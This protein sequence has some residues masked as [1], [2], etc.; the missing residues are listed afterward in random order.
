M[1]AEP[2]FA[3]GPRHAS[4]GA[5]RGRGAR[6]TWVALEGATPRFASDPRGVPPAGRNHRSWRGL[7]QPARRHRKRHPEA[8]PREASGGGAGVVLSAGVSDVRCGRDV[9]RRGTRR[10][11]TATWFTRSST[12]RQ[13]WARSRFC[14]CSSLRRVFDARVALLAAAIVAVYPN[15]IAMTATLQFETVF[16]TL[17]LATVLVLLPAAIGDDHGRVRLL[18]SGA[19]IGAVALIHPTI[20]LLIFAFLAAR[21]TL[22]RPWRETVRDLSILTA[23]H[24][25]R[26]RAVDDPQRGPIA[27]IRSDRHR[28]RTGVVP[29]AKLRGH[30]EPRPRRS[31]PP[32]QPET[33]GIVV[34]EARSRG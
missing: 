20:G 13:C 29:V 3:T 23:M 26:D 22:R 2:R 27:R 25:A 5:G 6:V 12:C 34:A 17:L 14:S 15:L 1:V 8:T 33:R 32:M 28:R 9:D 18:V 7:R 11:P 16:I 4:R 21:L 30:R 10:F 31:R 24:R 19:L